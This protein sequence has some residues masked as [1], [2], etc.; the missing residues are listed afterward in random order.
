MRGSVFA[1]MKFTGF[2][3]AADN[4]RERAQTLAMNR[5]R[6]AAMAEHKFSRPFGTSF[7][8]WARFPTLKRWAIVERPSGTVTQARGR[9]KFT[10]FGRWLR[11][12]GRETSARR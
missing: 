8:L 5:T 10:R 12:V 1:G 7:G 2:S 11:G 3:S 9:R 4:G 6:E